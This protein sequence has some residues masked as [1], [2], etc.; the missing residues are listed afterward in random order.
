MA[1]LLIEGLVI[2]KDIATP[3]V[4]A[5]KRQ[6]PEVVEGATDDSQVITFICRHWLGETLAVEVTRNVEEAT[7]EA[8]D[9]IWED[10]R[11]E[12]KRRAA[13]A[14]ENVKRIKRPVTPLGQAAKK[15]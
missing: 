13:E 14:R 1:D 7:A 9:A 11:K 15:A 12:S 3:L 8:A 4:A 6:F 2:P 5:V 10:A